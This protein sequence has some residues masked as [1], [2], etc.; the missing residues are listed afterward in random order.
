M[1][2]SGTHTLRQVSEESRSKSTSGIR[3]QLVGGWGLVSFP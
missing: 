1:T 3:E 2:V